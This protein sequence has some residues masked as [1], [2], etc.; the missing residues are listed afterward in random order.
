[1]PSFE[2]GHSLCIEATAVS[3]LRRQ[4]L[5][6]DDQELTPLGLE[7]GNDGSS[8]ALDESVQSNVSAY[9]PYLTDLWVGNLTYFHRTSQF[10]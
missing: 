8:I 4:L 3:R 10:R 6:D 7:N 5:V 1:V 2:L 9:L